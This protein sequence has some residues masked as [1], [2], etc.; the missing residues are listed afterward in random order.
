LRL[1]G[2]KH[3]RWGTVVAAIFVVLSL[4][5]A[6]AAADARSDYLVR[7]LSGSTQFRVRAQAAISLGGIAGSPEVT[8]ALERA[9]R[10]EHP[11][12]RA[13]AANSL[14][15]VGDASALP[16]LRAVAKDAE[17]PVRS[18]VQAAVAKLQAVGPNSDVGSV[19]PPGVAGPSRYYIAVAKTVTRLPDVR[20][21]ELARA[22]DALRQRLAQID[23]VELA[24]LDESPAAVRGILRDRKL[25]GFYIDSSVTSVETKPGGGI[26]VAVSVILAT[27]PERAM[28]AIMQG[29]ATAVGGSDA[30]GQAVTSAFKSAVSQ[31]PQ[32]LTRD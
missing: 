27:Y 13:A 10:D 8:Q 6:H 2:D 4:S 15:R 20:A 29:A 7:L 18:A 17:A 1:P 25:K 16:A 5:S 9:L 22:H 11:A 31:L 23:G 19:Q 32:A 28:R 24:P 3:W 26:R 14:G 12:V 30:R 21:D